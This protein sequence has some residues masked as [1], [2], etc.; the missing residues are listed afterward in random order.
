MEAEILQLQE[1]IPLRA[2]GNET[3]KIRSQ[4]F[5]SLAVVLSF[6]SAT[7]AHGQGTFQ[8]L[9]FESANIPN[10]TPAGTVAVSSALP[11]WTVYYGSSQQSQ[12]GYQSFSLGATFVSLLTP[13]SNPVFN[14]INGN[15]SVLLQGGVTSTDASIVQTGIVPSSAKSILF[16]A[17]SVNAGTLLVSL[18]GQNIPFFALSSG[19]NYTEYGGDI[20]AFAGQTEQLKFSALYQSGG[21]NNWNIDDI[22]FSPNQIPEPQTWALLFCGAAGG[23][24]T[25]RFSEQSAKS[26]PPQSARRGERK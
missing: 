18:G 7:H 23:L 13:G 8:N 16:Y 10:G 17:E 6:I 21:N 19:P 9:D 15:Y 20:S 25:R 24:L 3:M 22:Q 4:I 14:S 11:S 12:M 5:T 26:A 2:A 1:P